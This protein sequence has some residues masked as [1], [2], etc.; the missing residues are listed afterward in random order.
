MHV[1]LDFAEECDRLFHAMQLD[2]RRIAGLAHSTTVPLSKTL[3]CL[4]CGDDFRVSPSN[5]AQFEN[6][7]DD[8]VNGTFRTQISEEFRE[9]LF[10]FYEQPNELE[11]FREYHSYEVI[12]AQNCIAQQRPRDYKLLCDRFTAE[13]SDVVWK[14][15]RGQFDEPAYAIMCIVALGYYMQQ[16]LRG[17][18]LLTYFADMC[19]SGGG[20]EPF[21]HLD[22]RA[23]LHRKAASELHV[24][25]TTT[26]TFLFRNKLVHQSGML[27]ESEE[28]DY[29]HPLIIRSLNSVGVF[30]NDHLHKCPNFVH[31]FLLWLYIMCTDPCIEGQ[32]TTGAFM[33]ELCA[34]MFPEREP[35]LR[36]LSDRAEE[37][38]R[39]Y[40]PLAKFVD[41]AIKEA[42]D[43]LSKNDMT[44]F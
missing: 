17:A 15:M 27:A 13:H 33:H 39:R 10:L 31:A 16:A 11:A 22:E 9:I 34:R 26:S 12:T 3:N 7:I 41:P 36:K 2:L 23:G 42:K 19:K 35:Q 25:M 21:A 4:G 43:K 29:E 37:R 24:K 1:N 18:R 8:Q 30:Y 44:Q 32:L 40:N 28:I 20:L 14:K 38:L 5:I 6:L